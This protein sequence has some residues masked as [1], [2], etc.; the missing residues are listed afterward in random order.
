MVGCFARWSTID[1]VALFDTRK[2]YIR[3]LI[4]GEMYQFDIWQL[5]ESHGEMQLCGARLDQQS[6]IRAPCGKQPKVL[7]T[8]PA[9]NR[10][11]NLIRETLGDRGWR[12]WETTDLMEMPP[13]CAYMHAKSPESVNPLGL[14]ISIT[15]TDGRGCVYIACSCGTTG[16]WDN[17]VAGQLG[18]VTALRSV[19]WGKEKK[20]RMI[21]VQYANFWAC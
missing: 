20:I 13:I 8:A 21:S 9:A 10:P 18:C 1:D 17:W 12:P 5:I 15:W 4:L 6:A 3:R 11:R 19:G 14:Q 2:T 16:L 7:G